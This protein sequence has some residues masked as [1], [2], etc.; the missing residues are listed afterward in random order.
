MQPIVT[1]H[2]LI[3]FCRARIYLGMANGTDEDLEQRQR[4]KALG[5]DRSLTRISYCTTLVGAAPLFL[6]D[7]PAQ[8]ALVS[9]YRKSSAGHFAAGAC[10][11]SIYHDPNRKDEGW[12]NR[13]F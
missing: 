7:K 2:S 13:K 10:V 11:D 6:R 5:H 3:R 4:K 9:G 12:D 8:S 1:S